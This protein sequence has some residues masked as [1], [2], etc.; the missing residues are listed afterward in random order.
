[1]SDVELEPCWLC[2]FEFVDTMSVCPRCGTPR[3][4]E[5]DNGG[6][7]PLV[8]PPTPDGPGGVVTIPLPPVVTEDVAQDDRVLQEV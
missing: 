2:G 5:D 3:D 4:D 6:D 7:M 8:Y 1:M